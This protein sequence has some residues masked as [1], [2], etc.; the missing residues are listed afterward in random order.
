MKHEYVSVLGSSRSSLLLAATLFA[1]LSCEGLAQ[2]PEAIRSG[3]AEDVKA[4]I[5]AMSPK[6]IDVVDRNGCTALMLAA[7]SNPNPSVITALVSAGADVNYTSPGGVFRPGATPRDQ[8]N[9]AVVLVIDRTA[10]MGKPFANGG[11]SKLSHVKSDVLQC[12]PVFGD[13]DQIGIVTY[14]NAGREVIELPLTA[15]SERES[16]HQAVRGL[17]VE[18]DFEHVL[19]GLSAADQMLRQSAATAKAVLVVMDEEFRQSRQLDELAS[20]MRGDG[21]TVSVAMINGQ[22]AG[23]AARAAAKIAAA[24]GGEYTSLQA[25]G[26]LRAELGSLARGLRVA[27]GQPSPVSLYI[28]ATPLIVAARFNASR[29]IVEELLEGG[30]DVTTT[31]S[32]KRTALMWAAA[33]SGSVEIV[34]LLLESQPKEDATESSIN[35]LLTLAAQNPNC[36]GVVEFLVGQGAD[37]NSRGE[38]GATALMLAATQPSPDAVR[39]L[40][41]K[42]AGDGRDLTGMTAL[43]YAAFGTVDA[44]RLLLDSGAEIDARDADGR[45]ALFHAVRSGSVGTVALLL[46]RGA[47]VDARV[48]DGRTALMAAA[49]ASRAPADLVALLLKAGAD[50]TVIDSSGRKAIDHGRVNKAFN[51]SPMFWRLND[52]SFK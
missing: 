9:A 42:G 17:S 30:A 38:S 44:A 1:E 11:E 35:E 32:T 41:A 34:K 52:K 10:S 46:E 16:I 4:A 47:N 39:L 36:S 13:R 31:D 29:A 51:G 48:Q 7:A 8:G 2:H 40:L 50:A 33:C 5:T 45:T 3:T 49:A 21:V 37:V 26:R 20:R 18:N 23:A 28:G 15:V 25:A 27:S 24:G 43:M 22:F 12:L 6:G 19:S 14:G